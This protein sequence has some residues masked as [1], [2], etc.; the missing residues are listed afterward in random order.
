[1][2]LSVDNKAGLGCQGPTK[3]P[4]ELQRVLVEQWD[5]VDDGS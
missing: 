1:M 2:R 5:S 4:K 3:R